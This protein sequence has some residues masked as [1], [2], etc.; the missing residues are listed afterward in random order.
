[1]G[2]GLFAGFAVVALLAFAVPVRADV[3]ADK[4]AIQNDFKTLEADRAQFRKDIQALVAAE[5]AADAAAIAKAKAAI[6]ADKT[7]I[8]A[9]LDQL[10]TDFAKLRADEKAA[11]AA[12]KAAAPAK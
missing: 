6:A 5:K 7:K 9:D 1:M 10:R 3:A 4:T 8:K 11:R 12:A 2:K